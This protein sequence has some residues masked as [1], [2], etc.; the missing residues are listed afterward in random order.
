[1]AH[2]EIFYKSILLTNEKV[3]NVNVHCVDCEQISN[4][5]FA[6]ARAETLLSSKT[7]NAKFSSCHERMRR[8]WVPCGCPVD[9]LAACPYGHVPVPAVCVVPV[10]LP[11]SPQAR[12]VE[13]HTH[14]YKYEH[15]SL[16]KVLDWFGPRRVRCFSRT[17]TVH[18]SGRYTR[19]LQLSRGLPHVVIRI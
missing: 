10:P 14:V 9:A 18:E 19:A 16:I 4:S 12:R 13:M 17:C 15:L 8:G 1:M 5:Q 3:V 7:Q 6:T 11:S 2:R